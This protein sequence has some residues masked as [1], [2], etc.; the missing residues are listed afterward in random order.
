M[1]SA[2]PLR[3]AIAVAVARV[4]SRAPGTGSSLEARAALL[5][6]TVGYLGYQVLNA[7]GLGLVALAGVREMEERA[8]EGASGV[9]APRNCRRRTTA[10]RLPR[11]KPA[12][13]PPVSA[14]PRG[15]PFP[16]G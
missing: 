5:G 2:S 14:P 8:S 6:V 11:C 7:F 4:S 3:F 1:P 12:P 10:G 15:L 13:E 16:R 9:G